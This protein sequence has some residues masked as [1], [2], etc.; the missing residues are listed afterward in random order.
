MTRIKPSLPAEGVF[1][2]R[3][4]VAG[5]AHPLVVTV[6]GGEIIDITSKDA[7]TVRD[8][9]ELD[10]AAG[11]VQL[12]QGQGDRHAR[13]GCR[14]RFRGRARCGEAVSAFAGRS[15]VGEGVGRH[16]RGQPAR[17]RHRGAGARLGGKGRRHSR[18]YRRADRPR[19]VQAQARLGRGDGDQGQADRARRLVAISGGRHRT[20]RRDFHQMPADGLGRVRRRCRPASGLDLEQPGAGDRRDRAKQRQDRRR[21]A[22]QRR[23]SARRRRALGAAA[24]QGQGQ[25]RI[26]S[27]RAVHPAVRRRHSR[28]TT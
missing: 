10:D 7:P 8:I 21:H 19:S 11:Y 20:G 23:Q 5:T 17:T 18:R 2:G 28:S 27:A 24:R 16:L 9:C 25:Q 22:R 13:R 26:G 12:R 4:R 1:L 14:Q 6:R 15:A 3:A